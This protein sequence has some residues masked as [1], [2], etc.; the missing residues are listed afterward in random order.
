M[1]M[2]ICPG[3]FQV[4]IHLRAT[5]ANRGVSVSAASHNDGVAAMHDSR[6]GNMV[7]NLRNMKTKHLSSVT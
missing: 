6:L 4:G 5:L 7:S 1:Q 3:N 2:I